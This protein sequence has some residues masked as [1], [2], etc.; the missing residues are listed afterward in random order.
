MQRGMDRRR[1]RD[2]AA[3]PA[4]GPLEA[5]HLDVAP[6]EGGAG[7]RHAHGDGIAHG[8]ELTP[9][10]DG[11]DVGDRPP[12][13]EGG[14]GVVGPG[15]AAGQLDDHGRGPAAAVGDHAEH[16]RGRWSPRTP[17]DDTEEGG[18][19]S[20]VTEGG[21]DGG[22]YQGA[23]EALG[24]GRSQLPVGIGDRPSGGHRGV[25]Q[26]P[27]TEGAARRGQQGHED[28]LAEQPPVVDVA[29]APSRR[30]P[31]SGRRRP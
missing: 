21:L 25:G 17:P 12:D 30:R 24:H 15:H 31:G 10:P 20:A 4:A 7:R 13:G 1:R 3:Q 9:G 29:G 2:D 14:D 18:G 26:L 6:H 27:G 8:R 22:R 23:A 19:R 5:E 11:L 16:A 28:L